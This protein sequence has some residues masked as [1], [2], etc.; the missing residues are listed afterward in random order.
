MTSEW[1][2]GYSGSVALSES[3]QVKLSMRRSSAHGYGGVQMKTRFG[4][5]LAGESPGALFKREKEKRSTCSLPIPDSL[6]LL[7]FLSCSLL[8]ASVV[9]FSEGRVWSGLSGVNVPGFW[10]TFQHDGSIGRSK[11]N[12]VLVWLRRLQILVQTERLHFH[13]PLSYIGEGNGNPLHC[14]CL[15]NPRDRGAWWAAIYGVTQTQTP[16]KWLKSSSSSRS[17]VDPTKYTWTFQAAGSSGNVTPCPRV[18]LAI[19]G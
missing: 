16:L 9:P 14:S 10:V 1:A 18:Y 19:S 7:R 5:R 15:E 11:D 17:L 6:T 8:P 2:L 13:F 12:L 4:R 3:N